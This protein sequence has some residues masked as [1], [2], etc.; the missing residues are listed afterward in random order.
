M[1]AIWLVAEGGGLSGLAAALAERG[2]ALHRADDGLPA[3]ALELYHGGGLVL[4]DAR[5]TFGRAALAD[6][7]RALVPVVAIA[8]PDVPLPDGVL[9]LLPDAPARMAHHLVEVLAEPSNLR[10]HPRVPIALPVRIA[11]QVL[12]TVDVS[13][14]GLRVVPDGPWA[15]A[16]GPHEAAVYLADGASI[17]LDVQVV[18]R[19]SDGVALRGRPS[20]DEDL[21]LWIHLILGGLEHSPLHADADPFGPLFA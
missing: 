14:Y 10:R 3:A 12:E 15:D 19:R 1:S 7:G 21:L 18:A 5:T 17:A 16:A 4:V 2:I 13:L 20:T 8:P 6:G 9:R 11:G